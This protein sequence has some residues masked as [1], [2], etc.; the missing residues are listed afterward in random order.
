MELSEYIDAARRY[1][2][3]KSDRELSAKLGLSPTVITNYR[4]GIAWPSDENMVK[5]ARLGGCDPELAVLDLKQWSVKEPAKSIYK[6][7]AKKIQ[8]AGAASIFGLAIAF[9][10]SPSIASGTGAEQITRPEPAIYIMRLLRRWLH[11]LDT[12]LN[13][14]FDAPFPLLYVW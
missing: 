9:T 5:I 13:F 11:R 2:A 3:P 8:L 1:S 4:R 7:I 12:L 10:S 6:E 14:R